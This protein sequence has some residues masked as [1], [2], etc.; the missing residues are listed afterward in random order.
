MFAAPKHDDQSRHYLDYSR[1]SVK[2][3]DRDGTSNVQKWFDQYF[4]RALVQPQNYFCNDLRSFSEKKRTG[5]TVVHNCQKPEKKT[6]SKA[7]RDFWIWGTLL[8][9]C[10]LT[11]LRCTCSL[12]RDPINGF[13]RGQAAVYT[14]KGR[15][16][17]R[18]LPFRKTEPGFQKN[19]LWLNSIQIKQGRALTQERMFSKVNV[20]DNRISSF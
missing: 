6:A 8:F 18:A 17:S 13:G 20:F 5:L 14:G 11:I 19:T 7:T 15:Q 2:E 10:F 16:G 9:F 1:N 3:R 4:Q 12:A